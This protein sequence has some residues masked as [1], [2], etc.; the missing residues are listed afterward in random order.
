MRIGGTL[1]I[2]AP[3]ILWE[4]DGTVSRVT[5]RIALYHSCQDHRALR[6]VQ[7]PALCFTLPP[8][9]LPSLLCLY[10]PFGR[11]DGEALRA[12]G[13]GALR[14]RVEIRKLKGELKCGEG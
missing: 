14:E 1:A 10:P 3:M 2:I 11:V 12:V 8:L 13:E 9:L 7:V 5:L 6:E 4:R